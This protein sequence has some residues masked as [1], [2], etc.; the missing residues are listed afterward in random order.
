MSSQPCPIIHTY[1]HSFH[2]SLHL[3]IIHT[4][5]SITRLHSS[6]SIQNLIT[7]YF[8]SIFIWKYNKKEIKS[9]LHFGIL[10]PMKMITYIRVFLIKNRRKININYGLGDHSKFYLAYNRMPLN[11]T[12]SFNLFFLLLFFEKRG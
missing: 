11:N 3:S 9:P 6:T 5:S 2:P 10:N 8:H 4:C 1:I 12:K 7:S